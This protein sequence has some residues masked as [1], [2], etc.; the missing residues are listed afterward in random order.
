MPAK[1]G[2]HDFLRNA[3]LRGVSL[4][5]A[6]YNRSFVAGTSPLDDVSQRNSKSLMSAF[7]TMTGVESTGG[8][9]RRLRTVIAAAA[10]CAALT[11][12]C[13]FYVDRPVEFFVWHHQQCRHLFQAMASP[14]LLSLPFALVYVTGYAIAAPFNWPPGPRTQKCLAISFAILA[15]TAMKDELK[16]FIGRPWPDNWMKFGL[17]QFSPLNDTYLYGSFPSGHTA[18]I[19]APMCMLCYLAPKYKP[20]WIAI[21]ATVMSGLVA[22]GYHYIADVIAGLFVGYAAAA[23]TVALMPKEARPRARA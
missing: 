12:F 22:A 2:I 14:S 1:A 20:L 15:A 18:Y 16:W 9:W 21:I 17:Y 3:P 19:A 6:W 13:I 23:C 11:T 7:A 8:G 10:L 4:N 5:A